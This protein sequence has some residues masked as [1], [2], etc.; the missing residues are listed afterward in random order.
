MTI[1]VRAMERH[2]ADI[3]MQIWIEC[4]HDEETSRIAQWCYN[5]ADDAENPMEK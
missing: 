2:T 1:I 3:R 5:D 4:A